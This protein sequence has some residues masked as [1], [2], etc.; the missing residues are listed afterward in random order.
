[1]GRTTAQ[2]R[3]G[4]RA[5]RRPAQ[6]LR[7]AVVVVGLVLAGCGGAADDTATPAD[8][9]SPTVASEVTGSGADG[10]GTAAPAATPQ[11]AP[12]TTGSTGDTAS[13]DTPDTDDAGDAGEQTTVS[14]HW[15]TAEGDLATGSRTA[16]LPAVGAGAV[17]ALLSGPTADERAS[18]LASAIPDG[19]RLLDLDIDDGLATVDLSSE[20]A[21]GGG[22]ASM[23]GRVAQIVYTLTQ[24]PTVDAVS[25]RIDGEAIDVL[26]GEGLLLEEPVGRDRFEDLAG[27]G[28]DG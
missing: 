9:A 8:E 3:A 27:P 13:G 19:T 6:A 14:V 5:E 17:R 7:T 21:G 11:P 20:F 25:F 16:P 4:T 10:Q 26:G 1:M 15:L 18:G 24:F 12:T 22:S 28:L 2:R 23:R